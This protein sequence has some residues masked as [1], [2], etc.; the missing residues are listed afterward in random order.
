MPPLILHTRRDAHAW[1]ADVRHQGRT[2]G[3]VPTMGALHEGHLSLVR[4]ARQRCDAVAVSLFVNPT[5]FGPGE[6]LSRYPRTLA[7][8]LEQLKAEAVDMVFVPDAA[9]MYPSDDSTAINPPRA[10]QPWEGVCRPGHFAG[11]CTVCL[12]LFHAVPADTAVFGAKDYQQAAVIKAMVRDLGLPLEIAVCPTVREADGLAMSSRNRYLSADERQRAAG[13][14]RALSAAAAA[15]AAGSGV[16][17]VQAELEHAIAGTTDRL[18]YV[19][20]VDAETLRPAKTWELPAVALVA[21]HIGGTRLI[22]NLPLP[23]PAEPPL[24]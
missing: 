8:D 21:A 13:I 19:A 2:V 18:D 4:A 10:A 17:V 5:Q 22:D 15:S 24:S 23:R 6:D 12:K 3:F 20:I 9:E 11:V 7:Q 14:Y 1:T 16:A